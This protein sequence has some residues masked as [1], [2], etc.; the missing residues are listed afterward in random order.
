MIDGEV[1]AE[2]RLVAAAAAGV[3]DDDDADRLVAQRAVPEGGAAE[4]QRGD[5][6]PVEGDRQRVPA[7]A[8]R[9]H[10]LGGGQPVPLAA[11]AAA[12]TGTATARPRPEGRVRAQAAEH[13]DV[14]GAAFQ[15]GPGRVGAVDHGVD[16]ASVGPAGHQG[17]QLAGQR[18]LGRA[19]MGRVGLLRRLLPGRRVAVGRAHPWCRRA[20]PRR[21]AGTAAAAR[22]RALPPIGNGTQSASTTQTCPKLQ[23]GLRAD[24]SN[25]SWCIVARLIP[26]PVLRASVSSI[27]TNSGWSAGIQASASRNTTCPTASRLHVARV[28][29]RWN[30]EMWRRP[31]PPD[32]SATAVIVRRPR[33]WIHPATTSRNVR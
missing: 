15:E 20:W 29:N 5:L 31:T 12:L 4:D 25:G 26:L 21:T 30:T 22:S 18:Q 16:G 11:W 9:G 28:K 8:G 23:N 14:G 6:P 10:R 7:A 19:R 1:G 13:L 33:Q 27:R 32:A 3:S 2:E 17:Q 24:D